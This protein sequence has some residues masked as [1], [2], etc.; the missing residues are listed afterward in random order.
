MGDGW[1]RA[2]PPGGLVATPPDPLS[3]SLQLRFT[4]EARL[5]LR[6]TAG[7][8][9]PPHAEG[10]RIFGMNGFRGLRGPW[11]PNIDGLGPTQ[12][13]QGASPQLFWLKASPVRAIPLICKLSPPLSGKLG[14]TP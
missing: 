1:S 13:Y 9:F 10:R 7:A 2:P 6:L 3:L 5:Q 11:S 8:R 14:S 4:A 12:P